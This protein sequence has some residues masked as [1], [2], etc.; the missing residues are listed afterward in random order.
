MV[1]KYLDENFDSQITIE[2]VA[3]KFSI[4]PSNLAHKFKD[5]VNVSF[6]RYV[7]FRRLMRAREMLKETKHSISEIAYSCG[8]GSVSQFNRVFR[9]SVG[10]AP[11]QYRGRN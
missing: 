1:K 6:Q 11:R 7:N 10:C 4:S 2:S 3:K 5:T 9:S 8:F